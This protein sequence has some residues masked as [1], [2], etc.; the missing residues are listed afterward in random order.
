MLTQKDD[1]EICALRHGA[2]GFVESRDY[3]DV[4]PALSTALAFA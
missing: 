1:V 3:P 2:A 4:V